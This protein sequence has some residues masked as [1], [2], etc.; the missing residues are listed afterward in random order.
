MN[1]HENDADRIKSVACIFGRFD[2]LQECFGILEV[3]VEFI[4]VKFLSVVA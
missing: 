1:K 4:A 2:K 3:T